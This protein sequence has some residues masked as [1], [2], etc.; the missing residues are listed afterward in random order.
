MT[1]WHAIILGVVQGLTEFLPI[2]S[3]AH[4]IIVPWLFGWDDPGLAFDAAIHLGTLAAA[5]IYFWRDIVDML[6]AV[7]YALSRPRLLWEP[8]P[9]GKD[10]PAAR[11]RDARLALLIVVATI[12][13][14]IAGV[15]GES[16]LDDFYHTAGH[17]DRGIVLIAIASILLAL[18][19]LL[20]ERL[21]TL[22]RGLRQIE[23]PDALVI[24]VA[25]AAA[26]VPGIS[27]SGATITTGLFRGLKRADAARYSFLLGIPIIAGA[28][29]KSVLDVVQAGLT[30]SEAQAFIAGMLVSGVVGFVA[31]WGLLR[32]LQRASTHVFSAYRIVLGVALLIAVVVR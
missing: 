16:A 31:I 19:L 18:L 25:Q 11:E 15:L 9:A 1:V 3:S 12:P 10:A 14:A 32:F 27:R 23:L 29:L 20:A 7:P 13:G 30:R 21:A 26:I 17:R 5:I 2:S 4:L 6:R 22:R 8:L 28:G 24:G